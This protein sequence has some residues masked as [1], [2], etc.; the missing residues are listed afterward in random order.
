[1]AF[2]FYQVSS[3][4][5]TSFEPESCRSRASRNAEQS[6]G[7]PGGW[8]GAKRRNNPLYED[9]LARRPAQL[10]FLALSGELSVAPTAVS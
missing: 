8:E 2:L 9:Q 6:E 7:G 5:R 1:V 4:V 10:S 3:S